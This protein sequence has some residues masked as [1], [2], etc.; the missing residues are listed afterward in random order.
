MA[1]L[2]TDYKLIAVYNRKSD[3]NF[4]ISDKNLEQ[5]LIPKKDIALT[6]EHLE[7]TMR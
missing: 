2:D 3:D 7:K 5:Y 4:S 6:K 1:S